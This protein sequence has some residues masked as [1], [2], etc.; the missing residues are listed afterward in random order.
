ME[1]LWEVR[2]A[3]GDTWSIGI[4]NDNLV[5]VQRQRSHPLP[6]EV[7]LNKF[8]RSY[9]ISSLMKLLN[10]EEEK[11]TIYLA[12]K[13]GHINLK[14][15]RFWNSGS[16]ISYKANFRDFNNHPIEWEEFFVISDNDVRDL[17]EVLLEHSKPEKIESF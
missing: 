10:R 9:L 7:D 3:D 6:H 5:S 12:I 1:A 11:P 16:L 13:I 2:N 17:V 4:E 15:H 8:V 14:A